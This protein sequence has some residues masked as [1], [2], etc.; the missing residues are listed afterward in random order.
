MITG[1]GETP[2]RAGDPI[3]GA[4]VYYNHPGDRTGLYPPKQ[5]PAIVLAVHPDGT[6][7]LRVMTQPTWRTTTY[8]CDCGAMHTRNELVSA[9]GTIENFRVQ[10]GVP[11]EPFTWCPEYTDPPQTVWQTQGPQTPGWTNQPTTV[12]EQFIHTVK[13]IADGQ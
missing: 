2:E 11:G 10:E 5:S 1:R 7:D 4:I 13:E 12:R 8:S 6:I 3:P 9:G